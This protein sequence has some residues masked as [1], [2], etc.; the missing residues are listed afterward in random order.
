VQVASSRLY[1]FANL[2]TCAATI[3]PF[4]MS[5]QIAKA[6]AGDLIGHSGSAVPRPIVAAK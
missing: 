2:V 6:T 4:L 3:I 5:G 1:R